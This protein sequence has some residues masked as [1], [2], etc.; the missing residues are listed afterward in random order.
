MGFSISDLNPLS[1]IS[2][3]AESVCDAVLPKNLE[4]VGDLVGIATSFETGD[5]LGC[6]DGA[7]DLF[8]DLPQQLS[9][10]GQRVGR[11][12]PGSDSNASASLEPTPP[13][14]YATSSSARTTT[15]VDPMPTTRSEVA[16]PTIG[17]RSPGSTGIF[18]PPDAGRS[19]GATSNARTG[20]PQ[21]AG[22]PSVRASTPAVVAEAAQG[23]S[24]DAFFAL[25]DK[26]LMDAVRN[27]TIPDSVAKD[28][29]QM[30][31]L[32]ARMNDITQMNQLITTMLNALHEMNKQVIQNIRA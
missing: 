22:A 11:N 14:P 19:T 24:P 20:A 31:R 13:T 6:L 15:T 2:N 7:M 26:D 18:P 10:L 8:K 1:L 16:P 25:T 17:P 9:D 5:W 4:F 21:S 12:G 29:K 28:P 23:S 3:A 32:Q 27:G 30:Q